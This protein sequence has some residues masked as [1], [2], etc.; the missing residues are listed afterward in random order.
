MEKSDKL[1]VREE[2]VGNQ[3]AGASGA[4]C[5]GSPKAIPLTTV[6]DLDVLTK[7]IEA[8]KHEDL[9]FGMPNDKRKP[10]MDALL[11]MCDSN[12]AKNSNVDAIPC[13]VSHV[14]DSKIVDALVAKNLNVNESLIVQLEDVLENWP[15]MIRNSP[16]IL[17]KWSMKDGL[18]IIASQIDK[19]IMLDSYTSSMCIKSWGRSSFAC[20]L[21]EINAEDAL[22][23]SLT[24]GVLLIKDTGFTI[25]TVS[26]PITFVTPNV[27]MTNDGFQTVGKKK[28]KGKSKSTNGG[29][30]C[31]HSVKQNI[32]YEPKATISAPKKG[33]TN[34]GNISKASSI[35]NQPYK[36]TNTSTKQGKITMSN[37]YAALEEESDEDV[38]N[39]YHELANLFH[40]KTCE[41]LSTF[42]TASG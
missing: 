20:C 27:E 22:K 19:P 13:M 38:E 2:T 42:T 30:I 1:N 23:E 37:S 34:L 40:C 10:V 25:E 11:A 41:S 36:A 28:K 16:I 12:H 26:I 33:A 17:N 21:I 3:G 4:S 9:L 32:R 5:D 39:V 24:I 29:Q 8:G 6:G 31:G 35:K 7:Y 15:W 14:D 18:S